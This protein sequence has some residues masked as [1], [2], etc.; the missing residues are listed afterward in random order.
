MRRSRQGNPQHSTAASEHASLLTGRASST[1]GTVVVAMPCCPRSVILNREE[2]HPRAVRRV[3][4]AHGA[5]R[6]E[7]LADA[8]AVWTALWTPVWSEP[9][10]RSRQG[11]GRWRAVGR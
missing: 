11:L 3:A 5:W 6:L 2:L 1:D 8:Q 4:C 7:F 9:A 10:L